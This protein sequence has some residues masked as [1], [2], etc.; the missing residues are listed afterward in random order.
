M[1]YQPA[2]L[3]LSDYTEAERLAAG[4][5]KSQMLQT[6]GFSKLIRQKEG[7]IVGVHMLGARVSELIGEGQHFGREARA[8]RPGWPGPA[9]WRTVTIVR[10]TPRACLKRRGNPGPIL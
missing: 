9:G 4:N 3:Q 10:E 1:Y 6:A 2:V 5:P 8:G 7:P